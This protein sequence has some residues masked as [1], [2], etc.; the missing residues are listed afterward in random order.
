MPL[1]DELWRTLAC[2]R[3]KGALMRETRAGGAGVLLEEL[4]CANCQLAY[5]LREGVPE[6]LAEEAR[7]HQP[8]RG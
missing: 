6:L 2:P 7:P 1:S 8:S 5:P 3:C 4:C